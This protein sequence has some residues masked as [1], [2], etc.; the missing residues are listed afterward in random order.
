MDKV[1]GRSAFG[2]SHL[3]LVVGLTLS[4]L[5]PGKVSQA[6]KIIYARAGEVVRVEGEV[7]VKRERENSVTP[8]PVNFK[9]L[10]DDLV[11][12]SGNGRAE[13]SL[14]PE[15]YLQIGPQSRVRLY[16]I[17]PSVIHFDIERGE[18]LA[19]VNS[20]SK[21]STLILDTPPTPLTVLKKGKYRIRV[22]ADGQ[23]EIIVEQGQLQFT[24]NLNKIVKL[25]KHQRAQISSTP[26]GT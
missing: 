10:P 9:L 18:V 25:G 13:L 20:L 16:E 3:I 22:G 24:G 26:K 15:S 2:V 11:I 14:N 19:L 21:N 8:L 12:T 7:Q 4:C 5:T 23:S 1:I 17:L 6:Q